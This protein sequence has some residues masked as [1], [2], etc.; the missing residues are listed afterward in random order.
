M[1]FSDAKTVPV[2]RRAEERM[3]A[4]H[5][6]FRAVFSSPGAAAHANDAAAEKSLPLTGDAGSSFVGIGGRIVSFAVQVVIAVCLAAVSAAPWLAQDLVW[7]GWLGTAAGLWLV[8]R[9]S[10]VRRILWSG[11]CALFAIALAFHWSPDVLA[12]TMNSSFQLGVIVFVPLVIWDATRLT[13]SAHF[14]GIG[15]AR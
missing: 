10:G 9:L 2:S 15:L 12:Y 4:G 7:C 6:T 8:P 1:D 13:A 3:A 5:S 11:G 14:R